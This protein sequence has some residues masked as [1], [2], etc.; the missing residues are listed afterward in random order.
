ME[1]SH[2]GGLDHAHRSVNVVVLYTGDKH[3][4]GL[5][6]YVVL[7]GPDVLDVTDVFIEARI[8]CHMFGT[9][10]K[11]LP[12]LVLILDVETKGYA[13][14]ILCHHLLEEADSQV[15]T[16]HDNRLVPLVEVIDDFCQLLSYKSTLLFVSF[17]GDPI[18]R[19]VLS[20]FLR[21]L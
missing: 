4:F 11:S 18:L 21:Y 1:T 12:M 15:D 17:K 2:D 19:C 13:C 5:L 9:N 6:D 16:F 3:L 14:R 20:L 10:G 8:D 7:D